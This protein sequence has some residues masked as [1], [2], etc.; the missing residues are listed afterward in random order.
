MFYFYSIYIECQNDLKWVIK[1]EI[2]IDS[3]NM[4]L[5][6]LLIAFAFQLNEA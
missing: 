5:D 4:Y 3:A 1:G 6:N 2:I